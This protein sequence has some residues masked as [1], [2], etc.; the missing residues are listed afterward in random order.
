ML[1]ERSGQI[2][3]M[4]NKSIG[5]ISRGVQEAVLQVSWH[6]VSFGRAITLQIGE[7]RNPR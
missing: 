7:G 5:C 4:E 6:G 1:C 3:S 2:I